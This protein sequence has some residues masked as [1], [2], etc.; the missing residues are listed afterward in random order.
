MT[1]RKVRKEISEKRRDGRE[2]EARGRRER[3]ILIILKN[4]QKLT[5]S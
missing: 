4:Y 5:K 1:R 3:D 2:R